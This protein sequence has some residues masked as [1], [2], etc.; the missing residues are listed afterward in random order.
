M[1]FGRIV[2]KYHSHEGTHWCKF[3]DEAWKLAH[4]E[5]KI[6]TKD[7]GLKGIGLEQKKAVK[8]LAIHILV[9]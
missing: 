5:R 6:E 4:Q 1:G 2:M 8:S 9:G 7:Y 3:S